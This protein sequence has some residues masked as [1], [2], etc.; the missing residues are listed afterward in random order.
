MRKYL[1]FF[2]LL[3]FIGFSNFGYSQVKKIPTS[4]LANMSGTS[5]AQLFQM[6]RNASSMGMSESEILKLYTQMGVNGPQ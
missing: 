5:E 6:W 3:T 2:L 4:S 1:F